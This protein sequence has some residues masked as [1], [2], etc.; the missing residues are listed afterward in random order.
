M[1]VSSSALAQV[2]THPVVEIPVA[3]HRWNFWV[4]ASEAALYMAGADM[5]G[6]MTLIPFLFA[7]TGIDKAWIGLFTVAALLNALGNPIGSAWAGGRSRKLPFCVRVGAVQRLGFL[8]VPLGALFLFDRPGLLLAVLVLAWTQTNLIGG[9]AAPVYQFVITNGT[10]ESWW[11]RMMGMRSVLAAIA[12]TGAT[13]FVWWV[14]RAFD[15]PHNYQVIGWAGVGML[16]GSL[17]LVSRFR[18]VPMDDRFSRGPEPLAATFRTLGRILREDV[19]V[20]WIAMAHVARSCGFILGAYMT[21]ALVERCHLS[22]RDMW[23]PVLLSTLPAILSHIASGWM[24]DRWGAKP[25]LVLSAA[26]T[27]ANSVLIMNCYHLAG[28]TVL[29]VSGNFAGSLMMNAWPTLIMKLSPK[30]LR[31]AYF[32]TLSMATAPGNLL[33]M[34]AGIVLVRYTGYDYVFYLSLLGG[35]V[36]TGLFLVK[37]PNI[38]HAP[39]SS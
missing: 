17:Y 22:N 30:E 29:F 12:G 23:I 38:R 39:A 26:L 14:N 34:T 10:W 1:G 11:G 15:T 20:R 37:L 31:H 33:V 36:A 25:A 24:V 28:F 6:P 19:R 7:Q 35:L 13:V 8:A 27:A 9:I 18:E 32:T 3:Q 16:L 21:A 4:A 5:M 2:S